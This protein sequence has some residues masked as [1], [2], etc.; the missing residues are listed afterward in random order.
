MSTQ[1]Y[2]SQI[3]KLSLEDKFIIIKSLQDSI[4]EETG[5]AIVDPAIMDMIFARQR[6]LKSGAVSSRPWEEIKKG[7]SGKQ[8]LAGNA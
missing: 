3:K 5:N 4:D 2:I 6:D 8:R 7:L 1:E